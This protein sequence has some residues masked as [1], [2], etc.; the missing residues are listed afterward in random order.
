MH[1]PLPFRVF[2]ASPSG[3]DAER[4]IVQ[5]CVDAFNGQARPE[6]PT[7][8]LVGWEQVRGTVGRP[9]EAI[10]ELISESHFL[11][12]LF[13]DRWGSE[14]GSPWGFTSGTEEELFTALSHLGDPER[15]MR[16]VWVAFLDDKNPAKEITNLRG[17]MVSRHALLFE[18]ASGAGDLKG[19]LTER[20]RSWGQTRGRKVEQ[21]VDLVPSSGQDVLRALAL[22]V[23]GKKLVELG[24]PE[25]GLESLAEAARIGGPVEQLAYAQQLARAGD[26]DGAL[27]SVDEA[28]KFYVNGR[29]PLWTPGAA[30]TFAAKAGILRRKGSFGPAISA[31]EHALTLLNP[32]DRDALTVRCRI[33]DELGLAREKSGDFREARTNFLEALTAREAAALET[34]QCQSRINL[35]RLDLA[36][37]D[38]ESALEHVEWALE[39]LRH[40]PS[41]ALHANAHVLAAQIH[42]RSHKPAAG[43]A[44]ARRA[45]EINQMIRNRRGEAISLNILAQCELGAG[46]IRPA[47]EHSQ[48]CLDLN[49][50]INDDFGVVQ[51]QSLLSKFD[52][53]N[54]DS[55]PTS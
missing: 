48:A 2:L 50:E 18:T 20:L 39:H 27:S 45:L 30:E 13:K 10:N 53:S 23:R 1:S 12:A 16:N 25:K 8:E 6:D 55:R 9:Q 28:I 40:L 42:L 33:L 46:E 31:L 37:D 49:V 32:D 43:I 47:K 3:L 5:D 44:Q 22:R 14:P 7:F 19:K 41:S 26:L 36:E 17:Q 52:L 11:I 34:D 21:H 4:E 15:P 38:V 29:A 54:Q 51:A 24:L 35:A